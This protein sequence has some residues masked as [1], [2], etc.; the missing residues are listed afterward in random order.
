[1]PPSPDQQLENLIFDSEPKF[2][3]I[4]YCIVDHGIFLHIH[5]LINENPDSVFIIVPRTELSTKNKTSQK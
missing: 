1:M 5:N 2:Y 4:D 3:T